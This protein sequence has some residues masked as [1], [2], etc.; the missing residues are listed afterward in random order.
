MDFNYSSITKYYCYILLRS[1]KRATIWILDTFLTSL[2]FSIEAITDII[3]IYLHLQKLSGRSQLKAHSL[4][5]NHI[6]RSLL[7]SRL[8]LTNTSHQ[9]SLDTLTLNQCLL[10]KGPIVDMDNRF[11]ARLTLISVEFTLHLFLILKKRSTVS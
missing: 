3:P 6:L 1:L 9:L 7:E 5:Y 10:I 8:S 2:F 11:N 4:P